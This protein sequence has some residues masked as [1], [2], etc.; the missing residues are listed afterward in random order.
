V[1]VEATRCPTRRIV[2]LN[3][4]S[5]VPPRRFGTIDP[6]EVLERLDRSDPE[7]VRAVVEWLADRA[8][9][10]VSSPSRAHRS[11]RWLRG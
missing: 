5:M 4:R 2:P 6:A 3:A 9:N 11:A 8:G 10:A 7:H 1:I